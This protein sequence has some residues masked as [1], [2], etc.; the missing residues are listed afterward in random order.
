VTRNIKRENKRGQT[1]T[2]RGIKTANIRT[3]RA[4]V[5]GISIK[6]QRVLLKRAR[7]L[8]ILKLK[9]QIT[10]A[11]TMETSFMTKGTR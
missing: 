9:I 6:T 7:V 8:I 10:I 1:V 3:E 11:L 5:A 2:A 4:I